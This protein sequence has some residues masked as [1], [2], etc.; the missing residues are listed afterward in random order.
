[1]PHLIQVFLTLALCLH[2][3]ACDNHT[4]PYPEGIFGPG[5]NTWENGADSFMH[6]AGDEAA[7]RELWLAGSLEYGELEQIASRFLAQADWVTPTLSS[8][9]YHQFM[10]LQHLFIQYGEKYGVDYQLAAA[11]GFQE[12][13]LNQDARGPGGA[14]GVMQILPSTAVDSNVGIADIHQLE[15]N[16]EA[17][18]KYV[19]YL[20]DSYFPEPEVDRMNGT[21]MALAAYNIGPHRMAVMREKAAEMGYDPNSWFDNVELLVAEQ[22]GKNSVQY[23]ANIFRYY[24]AYRFSAQQ[25]LSEEPGGPQALSG[26]DGAS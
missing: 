20:R 7:L 18:I 12:S 10:A 24:L 23:V 15:A 13:R 6:D 2:I 21:L 14:I 22:V 4:A 3:A 5:A 9:D 17:G 11:V 25:Q 16:I 1:M 8:E 26:E 19:A